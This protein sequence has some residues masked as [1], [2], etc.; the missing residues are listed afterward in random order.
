MLAVLLVAGLLTTVDASPTE[1]QEAFTAEELV[2]NITKSTAGS[3]GSLAAQRF[4][5]GANLRDYDLASVELD[6][7]SDQANGNGMLVQ[8]VRD[9]NDDGQLSDAD[10]SSV[11]TLEN[12]SFYATPAHNTFNAP[13]GTVLEANRSYFVV[14]SGTPDG[15]DDRAPQYK[16][17]R[18]NSLGQDSDFGFSIANQRLWRQPT[19]ANWSVTNSQAIKLRLNGRV[20][21]TT[22]PLVTVSADQSFVLYGADSPSFTVTRTTGT[23]TAVDTTS[24]LDV[25][26]RFTQ[27]ADSRYFTHSGTPDHLET[28]TVT[29]PAGDTSATVALSGASFAPFLPAGD[30]V[31]AG[32]VTAEAMASASYDTSSASAD[33]VSVRAGAAVYLDQ[34]AYEVDESDGTLQA[35][36]LVR[37]HF[38]ALRPAG[39]TGIK[40]VALA[41]GGDTATAGVD[42]T[43]RTINSTVNPQDLVTDPGNANRLLAR[44]PISITIPDDDTAEGDETFTLRVTLDDASTGSAVLFAFDGGRALSCGETCDVEVTIR[45]HA[46]AGSDTVLASNISDPRLSG[47][48]G[49]IER[50]AVHS[51]GPHPEGYVIEHVKLWLGN[52]SGRT[53]TNDYV[54]I[55]ENTGSN[56]PGSL[57][58][59]L[60]RPS[61]FSNGA[62]NTFSVMSDDVVILQP[63]TRYWVVVNNEV[64]DTNRRI[65]MKFT[66]SDEDTTSAHPS[67]DIA[68]GRILRSSTDGTWSTSANALLMEISGRAAGVTTLRSITVRDDDNE[69]LAIHPPF[70]PG[71]SSTAYEVGVP[72]DETKVRVTVAATDPD[73][74]VSI[75]GDATPAT[76]NSTS[77]TLSTSS[78]D[79]SRTITVTGA[80]GSTTRT[81]TVEVIKAIPTGTV[82]TLVSNQGGARNH[83]AIL[84][85]T[86]AVSRVH[87]RIERHRLH[88]DIGRL[89][90][91]QGWV[92]QSQ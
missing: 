7:A 41:A 60:D 33:K 30:R 71:R 69:F 55:M 8:V 58:A 50:A 89:E 81:Y 64:T 86:S 76:P 21:P 38:G 73:A 29:I 32:S 68:N 39:A 54:Q 35:A 5:T 45:G 88:A 31:F 74:T 57:V 91:D 26:V 22:G 43:G 77:F 66:D 10:G 80:D 84:V 16:A 59:G 36:L 27:P 15:S 51:T 82:G 18:T 9:D 92:R 46:E 56:R 87:D 44:V 24:P 19:S 3:V 62:A 13:A 40:L 79:T 49:T 63:N 90:N 1:A 47:Q 6:L 25:Q 28:T 85:R 78:V 48:T 4:E 67:W 34:E 11:V 17:R 12:P 14:I 61:S 42:F 23:S 53:S 20:R 75:Q 83:P 72:S 52:S 70:D 37:N 65:R 2:S